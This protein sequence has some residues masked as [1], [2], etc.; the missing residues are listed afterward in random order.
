MSWKRNVGST[1]VGIVVCQLA[2]AAGAA[3]SNDGI[4]HWYPTLRKPSFTPP[5]WVFGPVWTL[6]YGCMGVALSLVWRRRERAK[7]ANLALL[8]FAAQLVV[9]VVWTFAFFGRRSTGAGVVVILPLWALIATTIVLFWPIAVLAAVL[10]IPYLLWVSFATA[11]N[12]RVWQLN[13]D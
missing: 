7:R 4:K 3:L 8:A 13:R 5:S 9:N 10:L 6:L 1:L 2:G 12:L 11:L